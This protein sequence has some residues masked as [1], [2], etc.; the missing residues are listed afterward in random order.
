MR[1]Q[2]QDIIARLEAD[3]SK[4]AKQAI[5]HDAIDNEL[6][7]FFDGLRMALDMLYT[8]G[9][10]KVPVKD[11]D[12]GQG[13]PWP[14]FVDLAEKLHNRE[15][16][17]HAAR[18]AIELA[19]NV[20]TQE[21]WNGYYRRILI[22][23]M[24]AG[25][26][27]STVNKVCKAAKRPDLGIP[28]FSCQLAHD[29]ANHEKKV[30]GEK[31]IEVKL[32]G[33]RVLTIVHPNGTVE[34]FSRNGRQL[35]NF[36]H[37][38]KQ[39]AMIAKKFDRAYVFDG[40]VMSGSFQDLMKQIHRKDNIEAADAVLH[41][42]D[43]FPLE[44]FQKGTFDMPQ[45]ERT[46]LLKDLIGNHEMLLALNNCTIVEQE[47]VDLDTEEGDAR[48]QEINRSAIA[49][50]YEG[51][52]LKDADAPYECKRRAAWLKIK[53]F[54]EVTLTVVDVEE[55]TGKNVGKMGALVCEGVDDGKDIRVNVGSGFSDKQRDEFWEA[56]EEVKDQLAEVK[57]DAVTQNQDGTYSLRFPRFKTFRGWLPGEK[58]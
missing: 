54:I 38:E 24:R 21:Q 39:F 7:E 9:V 8:F 15:L 14:A 37:I 17:G 27:E 22:K 31:L 42:F 50:G 19:M 23:D 20:A 41:L 34:M 52:M 40:E 6:T 3:N 36:G 53:P 55:G 25:F 12:A 11:E 43:V 51:I 18:D 56:R 1:T 58:V 45:R 48:F 32:D 13:L 16:T 28:V 46:Q 35:I 47:L 49:G 57:A 10:K 33:V 2:P 44:D 4:L 26:S 30:K 5:L 29:A